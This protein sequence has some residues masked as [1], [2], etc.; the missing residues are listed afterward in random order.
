MGSF[1]QENK[2]VINRIEIEHILIRKNANLE[3]YD[4]KISKQI[5]EKIILDQ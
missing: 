4:L 1:I 3:E 5:K 2:M